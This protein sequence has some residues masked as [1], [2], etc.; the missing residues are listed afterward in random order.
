MEFNP[1]NYISLPISLA[2]VAVSIITFIKKEKSE[3]F[4]MAL[5]L[6]IS[7]KKLLMN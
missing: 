5:D 7:S 4:R 2:A 1:A 6:K 3:Q